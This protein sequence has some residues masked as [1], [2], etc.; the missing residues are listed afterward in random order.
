MQSIESCGSAGQT[1]KSAPVARTIP[2][3]CQH[4]G[5]TRSFLYLQLAAGKL[6]A[7]KAGRRTLITTESADEFFNGLPR[8]QFGASKA[9]A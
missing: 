3:T 1:R 2:D 6:H 7:V 4:Y 8:A 5:W 9:A